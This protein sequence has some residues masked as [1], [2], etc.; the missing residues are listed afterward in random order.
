MTI[1]C[2]K[3]IKMVKDFKC[4]PKNKKQNEK[5]TKEQQ[6]TNKQIKNLHS[7]MIAL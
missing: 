1:N 6:K 4:F 3:S 7:N 2:P 5:K